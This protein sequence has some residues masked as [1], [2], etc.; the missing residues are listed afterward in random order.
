MTQKARIDRAADIRTSPITREALPAI[1]S[2]P[3]ST[4]LR[5]T[6][7]GVLVSDERHHFIWVNEVFSA[8]FGTVRL[9]SGR[10]TCRS[11]SWLPTWRNIHS[12]RPLLFPA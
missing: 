4:F 8:Y 1:F 12:I 10:W 3:L 7:A 6:N 2:L 9:M 5:N 11:K